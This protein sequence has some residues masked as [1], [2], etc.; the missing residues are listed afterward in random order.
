M[1][2]LMSIL[3]WM[4]CTPELADAKIQNELNVEGIQNLRSLESLRDLDYQTWQVVVYQ[5]DDK[6][7]L[8][9]VGFPGSLRLNHPEFLTVE[10]GIKTWNL[11][12]ITL[13]NSELSNDSRQAAAEFELQPLLLGLQNKRPLRLSLPGAFTELPIP[14]YLVE[15]WR[16]F[17]TNSAQ[18][19]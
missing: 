2:I 5:K 19:G 6:I 13:K 8:R 10:A 4:F 15:E 7:V 12:D 17:L 9:I 14:P 11:E 1:L 18:N 3:F 16:S